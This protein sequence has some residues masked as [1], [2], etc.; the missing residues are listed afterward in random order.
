MFLMRMPYKL[1]KKCTAFIRQENK[2]IS[3]CFTLT[4]AACNLQSN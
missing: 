3:M 1:I 2:L 4:D